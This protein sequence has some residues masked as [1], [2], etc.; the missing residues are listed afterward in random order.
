MGGVPDELRI[1]SG[2]EP[3]KLD[4]KEADNDVR[5]TKYTWANDGKNIKVF[6]EAAEEPRAV[7]AAWLRNHSNV[8]IDFTDSGFSMM[9]PDE[10]RSFVLNIPNLHKEIVPRESKV[11]VSQGK[12]ITVSC[13]KAD[14]ND[15]WFM[16]TRRGK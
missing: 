9:V 16:L 6:I 7:E 11:R 5:I 15:K 2:G 13:R 10:G 12:K 14:E 4:D 8:K 3:Q 1:A